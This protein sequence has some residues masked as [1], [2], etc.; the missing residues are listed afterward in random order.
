MS[1][2]KPPTPDQPSRVLVRIVFLTLLVLVAGLLVWAAV[3]NQR[4]GLVEDVS[5]D[6]LELEDVFETRDLTLHI[7][8][9]TGGVIPVILLHEAD[10]A[11]SVVW[12]DVVA[13]VGKRFKPVRLDLPGFG[14]SD[15]LPTEGPGH[16]VAAMASAVG[17]VVEERYGL[18]V[19]V[20]GA[21]LGG[22]VAAELAVT[23]PGLVRGLVLIDVDFWEEGG[24]E[25]FAEKLPWFGPAATFTLETGGRFAADRWAPHC[26]EGGWCP[27]PEQAETRALAASLRG[28][29][30]SYRSQLMTLPSSLVPSD[31]GEIVSPVVFVWS[32][33]GDVPVTSV[34]RIVDKL[35]GLTVVEVDAWKA[36]LDAPAEVA[37]AIDTVGR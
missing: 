3:T 21:G 7:V 9:E 4:I 10:I 19:V 37:A 22:K 14:L 27:T 31:L 35:P 36:H 32:T 12:D 20:V 2:Q 34:D 13:E 25:E 24:W 23:D 1:L 29:T 33:A 15:R 6:S 5:V 11:G 26:D 18:P 8:E 16:T 17:A 28:T 30:D